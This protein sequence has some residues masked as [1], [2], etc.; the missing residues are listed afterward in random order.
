MKARE[1]GAG[2][3]RERE[4]IREGGRA[5]ERST[6]FCHPYKPFTKVSQ[7]LADEYTRVREGRRRRGR[8]EP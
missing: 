5:V 3:G 7:V 8:E 4:R 1:G 2:K 6:N